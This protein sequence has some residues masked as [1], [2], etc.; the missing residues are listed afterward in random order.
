MRGI[1]DTHHHFLPDFYMDVIGRDRL[2]AISPTG[3]LPEWTLKGDLAMMDENGIQKAVLSTILGG[4]A[5]A[6][7]AGLARR[8]NEFAA[9]LMR[10]RP[11]RFGFFAALPLPDVEGSLTEAAFALDTLKATG[12]VIA[13]NYDGSYLGDA[14]F[15]P[16]WD[17]LHRRKAVVFIHP[18]MPSY[19]ATNITP[20][21]LEFPFDTTRT[22]TSLIYAGVTIRYPG[23]TFVLSHGGG[24]LPF[25]AG[26]I[27][28]PTRMNS[29][30]AKMLPNGALPEL[31]KFYWDTALAYNAPAIRCLL[32]ITDASK[33]MFGSDFP[34]AP[35]GIV[36]SA[37]K[38][39]DAELQAAEL[40]DIYSQSA[41]RLM[42]DLAV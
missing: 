22:A 28:E 35:A 27:D 18:T 10:E 5:N 40:S 34:Y 31:R 33:V 21:I 7:K 14:K 42:P 37:T 6:E 25:L 11:T 39:L 32:S 26:R 3:E 38:L 16:L 30:L 8:L 29:A 23:V 19:R 13:T 36:Q 1:I 9:D 41:L 15:E 2:A 24:A 20:S 4:P 17:E 12:L